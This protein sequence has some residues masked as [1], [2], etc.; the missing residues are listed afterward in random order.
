MVSKF[1]MGVP[2]AQNNSVVFKYVSER[3]R[4]HHSGVFGVTNYEY[5]VEKVP[6]LETIDP[7]NK[8]YRK[9]REETL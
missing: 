3:V 9:S 1:F 6:R 2:S 7:R 8:C 5:H 4:T